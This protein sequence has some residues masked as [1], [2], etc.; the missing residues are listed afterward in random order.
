MKSE[1]AAVLKGFVGFCRFLPVFCGVRR[2]WPVLL[3]FAGFA[4]FYE[5]LH[6][7]PG[8]VPF[9]GFCWVL[10]VSA[11]SCRVLKLFIGFRRVF[12][13]YGR[14]CKFLQVFTKVCELLQRVFATSFCRFLPGSTT[15]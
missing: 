3:V 9:V 11:G 7:W 10:Q 1:T 8:L 14:H 15:F 6:I 4:G 12:T 2:F 5:F 13:G